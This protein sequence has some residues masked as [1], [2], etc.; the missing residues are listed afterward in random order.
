V[1]ALH[2]RILNDLDRIRQEAGI[3][4]L[5]YTFHDIVQKEPQKALELIND[6]K[7]HF[8]TLFVLQPEI[9]KSELGAHL[10][11][12][13]TIALQTS[14]AILLGKGSES[15]YWISDQ[16][17]MTYPVLKWMLETGYLD[18]GM[19]D[20][21]DKVLDIT[22]LILVRIFKDKTILSTI[23]DLIFLRNRKDGFLYDLIWGLFETRT[24]YSLML[25]GQ[26]LRSSGSKD[27]NLAKKLLS[28]IPGLK[29]QDDPKK[30]YNNFL[31]WLDENCLFFR[32]TGESFQLT[33][34][35]VPYVIVWEAKYLCRVVNV[36]TGE[37]MMPLTE[38][39][40]KLLD[41]FKRLEDT[42]KILLANCSYH[43]YRKDSNWW[44]NWIDSPVLQQIKTAKAILG[45]VS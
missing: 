38:K 44:R 10:N 39:E 27:Q 2:S 13:N 11:R 41:Q 1:S 19:N 15:E 7:L 36:D 6:G 9:E 26:R 18:D 40:T 45:G 22:A 3:E 29:E 35:P 16:E 37:M 4:K 17:A 28:F 14:K 42:D 34:R 12:R 8:P 25:I 33:Q 5:N 30:L 23:A 24:P 32:Y 43:L 20:Q 21:Y 31:H